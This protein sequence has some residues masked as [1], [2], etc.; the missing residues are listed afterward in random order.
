MKISV[1]RF[2]SKCNNCSTAIAKGDG[3]VIDKTKPRGKRTFCSND[4]AHSS[5]V[6]VTPMTK[7]GFM[8]LFA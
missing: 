2:S 4:C 1:A 5:I 7:E 3:I 6:V 8:G